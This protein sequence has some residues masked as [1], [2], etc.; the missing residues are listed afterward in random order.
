MT[1]VLAF[2][3]QRGQ[4]HDLDVGGRTV[5]I[6]A[7]APRLMSEGDWKVGMY[8]DDVATDEQFA[9]LGAVFT[10]QRGGVWA[11][12]SPLIGS[13]LGLATLTGMTFPAP[14]LTMATSTRSHVD[15]FGIRMDSP[16][17]NGHSAP[18]SWAA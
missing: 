12:V 18:F 10:S 3:I 11:A 16:G 9:A 7:D 14:I 6:V 5:V 1:V 8:V 15:A 4:I 17:K 13:V 2:N